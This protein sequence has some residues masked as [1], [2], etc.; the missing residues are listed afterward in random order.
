MS[1]KILCYALLLICWCIFSVNA[2][3]VCHEKGK[4]NCSKC[5][6]TIFVR[7]KQRH[8]YPNHG[9]DLTPIGDTCS[10]NKVFVEPAALPKPKACP[11]KKPSTKCSTC[12]CG[13]S[14]PSSS[15][16][17]T[18]HDGYEAVKSGSVYTPAPMPPPPPIP[19]TSKSCGCSSAHSYAAYPLP[20][21]TYAKPTDNTVPADPISISLA[22]QATKAIT[23][24]EAK[25]A[26]G[27]NQQPKD[28][29]KKITFSN[30][31]E[32]NLFKLKKDVITYK[33]PKYTTTPV[34][35]EVYE[36]EPEDI[37]ESVD[38]PKL[39]YQ[40]LG[41]VTEKF[42]N[43]KFRQV[44]TVYG[45]DYYSHEAYPLPDRVTVDCGYKPGRVAA[46]IKRKNDNDPAGYY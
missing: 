35:E 13:S 43:P 5:K 22:L 2:G 33:K 36:H 23:V 21:A 37:V 46:Y 9:I 18:P 31:P 6:E 26:F 29:M 4:D 34:S 42:K 16:Y 24:P 28:S 8:G 12:K 45:D 39:T 3:C 20:D 14:P 7:P 19:Y 15:H 32:E 41:Y 44:H 10:C 38:S 25:L 1:P 30:V 11:H 17:P 27:F 40:Q